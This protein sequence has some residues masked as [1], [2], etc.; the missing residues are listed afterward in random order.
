[1]YRDRFRRSRQLAQDS[2]MTTKTKLD[3]KLVLPD[4]D[5]QHDATAKQ[6]GRGIPEIDLQNAAAMLIRDLTKKDMPEVNI[7]IDEYGFISYL[8]P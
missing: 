2:E 1:M 7:S 8:H 3:L 4:V 6:M 5:D